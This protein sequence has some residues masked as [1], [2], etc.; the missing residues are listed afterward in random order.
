MST[1]RLALVLIL[2]TCAS[3]VGH[4]QAPAALTGQI[5]TDQ[6][7]ALHGVLVS[8]KAKGKTIIVM[9]GFDG[10]FAIADLT[11]G[12]YDLQALREGF[13]TSSQS[14]TL[15]TTQPL[16]VA[17]SPGPRDRSRLSMADMAKA[18]PDS[19]YKDRLINCQICHSWNGVA[20]RKRYRTQDWVFGMRRMIANGFGRIEENEIPPMAE[21][22]QANFSPDSKLDTTKLPA[23]PIDEA[24]LDITY[25]SFDIPTHN[26]MPHTAVPDR[27]G[28]VWFTEYGANKIGVL[29]PA[30]G[31]MEEFAI[32]GK[33]RQSPH[34][35]M[36]DQKG[37][38]WFTEQ[39]S[40]NIGR[41]DPA[42]KSFKAFP[43]PAPVNKPEGVEIVETEGANMRRAV[44][45]H[46]LVADNRGHIWFTSASNPLMELDPETGKVV[47]HVIR[48]G[49]GGLYGVEYDAKR[50][51]V[52]YAGIGLDE[53]GYVDPGTGKVTHFAMLTPNSAPRRIHVDSKG[54]TWTNLYNVSKIA[55]IDPATGKVTEWDLPGGR[56]GRPYAFGFDAQERVW[57]TTYYDDRLHMFDPKTEKFTSYAM[58][59]KG[60]GMRDF[61]VDENGWVWAAAWGHDKVVAFK[62][63]ASSRQAR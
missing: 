63:N 13:K 39:T 35:I 55:R 8:A 9:S 19:P 10:K 49:G 15:P 18:L 17:L 45:P 26:A 59:T 48:K 52:W 1:F 41:F 40:G 24:S 4:S 7:R 12:S 57:T 51:R 43:I 58:P 31:E 16:T 21:Y 29:K 50:N 61:N 44:A 36:R 28:N 30:T 5:T 23:E 2:L 34:N 47:E 33:V 46:T 25:M 37:I 53:V 32:P 11:P 27:R 42:T 6:G 56:D 60:N 38:V 20:S 22:L 62:L 3:W 54:V 14:V